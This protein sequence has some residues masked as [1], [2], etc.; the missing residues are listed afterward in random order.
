MLESLK[1]ERNRIDTVIDYITKYHSNSTVKSKRK[2]V[3][4]RIKRTRKPMSKK[5]RKAISVRMKAFWAANR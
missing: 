5:A 4:K 3:L 2:R 1:S